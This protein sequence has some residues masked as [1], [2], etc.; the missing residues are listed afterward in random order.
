MNLYQLSDAFEQLKENAFVM[1]AETGEILFEPKDIDELN[2]AFDDKVDNI[3]SWIKNLN[4]LN[5][6][7]KEEKKSLDA[8]LKQNDKM[9]ESLEDYLTNCMVKADKKKFESSRNK[10]TFRK[11]SKLVFD[12][13]EQF[14][15]D[16][17]DGDFI[18]VKVER[19]VDKVA[20]KKLIT[21]G[22]QFEGASIQTTSNILIK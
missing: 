6:S 19:S 18:K 14:I 4:A 11:S 15:E 17:F 2:A 8:R 5:A 20:L 9:I 1:D 7:I 3:A 12:N 13:E 22:N 10:I 21:E 16:N